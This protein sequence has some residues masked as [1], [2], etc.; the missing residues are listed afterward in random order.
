MSLGAFGE[1]QASVIVRPTTIGSRS[2]RMVST[3]GSSGTVDSGSRSQ[4][5]EARASPTLAS[6]NE[7]SC[8]RLRGLDNGKVP[9]LNYWHE[10]QAGRANINRGKGTPYR[11]RAVVAGY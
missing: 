7:N 5:Q 8:L 3:S 1:T 9:S 10:T 4:E 2:R 6:G 11:N